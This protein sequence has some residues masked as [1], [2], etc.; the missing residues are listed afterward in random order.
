VLPI[1]RKIRDFSPLTL[2]RN[3]LR[4]ISQKL[5]AIL[6]NHG[7]HH[8]MK[9]NPP[10]QQTPPSNQSLQPRN[11]CDHHGPRELVLKKRQAAVSALE[12]ATK[13]VEAIN[14]PGELDHYEFKKHW[15]CDASE[16]PPEL[17][18]Y[19][20]DEH[21]NIDW[22]KV[23]DEFPGDSGEEELWVDVK[24]YWNEWSRGDDYERCPSLSLEFLREQKYC[25]MCVFNNMDSS[26]QLEFALM[27][28][29]VPAEFVFDL[30]PPLP[31]VQILINE[32]ADV[33]QKWIAEKSA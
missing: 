22:I 15:S 28:V 14:D 9:A 27:G 2:F 19:K 5:E 8:K 16:I 32:A 7:N 24:P 26:M 20:N 11:V 4:I 1:R 17:E 25:C 3:N 33:Y 29:P 21:D 13:V 23:R 30:P 31:G 10:Q 12:V 18:H 6:R